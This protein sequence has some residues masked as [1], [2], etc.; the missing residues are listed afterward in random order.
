MVYLPTESLKKMK[1]DQAG[2]MDKAMPGQ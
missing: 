2:F 1:A